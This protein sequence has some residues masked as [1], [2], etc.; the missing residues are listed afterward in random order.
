MPTLVVNDNSWGEGIGGLL[1]GLT[2]GRDP[3]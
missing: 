3:E 1:G 2:A